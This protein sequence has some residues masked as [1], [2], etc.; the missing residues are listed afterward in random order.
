MVYGNIKL[1]VN[2]FSCVY[3]GIFRKVIF[4]LK[5]DLVGMIIG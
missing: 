3:D 4:G 2:V 5:V 1:L